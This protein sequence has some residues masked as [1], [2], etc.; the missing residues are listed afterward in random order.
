MSAQKKEEENA[1]KLEAKA[2]LDAMSPEQKEAHLKAEAD[3][4]KHKKQQDKALK[5]LKKGS[6]NPLK[7]SSKGKKKK[8]RTSKGTAGLPPAPPGAQK[9]IGGDPP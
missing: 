5:L 3:A 8:G 1:K 6:K 7:R 4:E 2:S 9:K